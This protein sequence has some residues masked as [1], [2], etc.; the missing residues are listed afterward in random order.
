MCSV[1]AGTRSTKEVRGCEGD[2]YV[3]EIGNGPGIG[4]RVRGTYPIGTASLR[5][6]IHQRLRVNR[7]RSSLWSLE[8]YAPGSPAEDREGTRACARNSDHDRPI[9]ANT[10]TRN[11]TQAT[12]ESWW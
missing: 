4:G 5:V 1:R 9:H 2:E 12:V 3:D 10:K 7:V 8:E 6:A 11:G